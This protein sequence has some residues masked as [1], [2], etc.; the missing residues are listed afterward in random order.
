MPPAPACTCGRCQVWLLLVLL[1]L[2][3][4]PFFSVLEV[5]PNCPSPQRAL[6]TCPTNPCKV[7]GCTL[8]WVPH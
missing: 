1:L 2:L 7:S 4:R 3:L 5:S 8:L 6:P